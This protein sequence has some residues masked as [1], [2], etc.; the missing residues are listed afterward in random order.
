MVK[1][2]NLTYKIKKFYKFK[3][4]IYILLIYLLNIF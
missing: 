4:Y 2:L 3:S 1:H